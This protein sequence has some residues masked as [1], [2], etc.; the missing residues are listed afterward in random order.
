MW[1]PQVSGGIVGYPHRLARNAK[2]ISVEF[3]VDVEVLINTDG[4]GAGWQIGIN[5]QLLRTRLN[6]QETAADCLFAVT[7]KS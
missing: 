4:V 7:G 6:R 3:V 2:D 5:L 1:R